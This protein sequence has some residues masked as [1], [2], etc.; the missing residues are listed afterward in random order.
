VKR[1]LRERKRGKNES[2]IMTAHTGTLK[3]EKHSKQHLKKTVSVGNSPL[4]SQQ[5][6]MMCWRRLTLRSSKPLP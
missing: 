4:K 3:K 2:Q 6:A 5:K 1:V